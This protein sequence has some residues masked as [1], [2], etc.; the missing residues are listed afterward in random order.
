MSLGPQPVF[1]VVGVGGGGG[2]P[3][4]PLSPA[5]GGWGRPLPPWCRFP[6]V[7]EL[8]RDLA[9]QAVTFHSQ[10]RTPQGWD[11]QLGLVAS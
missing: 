8:G 2:G 11:S 5:F 1:L 4:P 7:S 9:N 6:P 10:G 3:P